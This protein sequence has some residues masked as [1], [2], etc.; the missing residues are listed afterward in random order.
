MSFFRSARTALGACAVLAL[1]GPAPAAAQAVADHTYT[2]EAIEAGSRVYVAECAL[3]HGPN[4]EGVDGIDL[5]RGLFRNAGSDEDLRRIITTGVGGSRM[6]AFDDLRPEEL[7]GVVAYIRAGFDPSGVAVRVGDAERGEAI[8][9]G[10]GRCTQ[11][12]RVNGEG[13]R[14]LA[15]DLSDIGLVRT[16]AAL[17]RTILDPT[18]ALLPINRPVRIVTKDGEAVRG[19]RL[20]E[21]THT[22]QV[23]DAQERLRSFVKADLAE[24]E[25]RTTASM[26]TPELTPEQVADLIGYLLTLRGLP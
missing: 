12:H 20:N 16:P 25:V 4:G 14:R 21:D 7:D 15:P 26:P 10:A 1:L 11:C 23:V 3:C 17:Q 9:A 18:S 13:G 24:Y 22:V 2:A 8:F 19:R 5:R 6:P